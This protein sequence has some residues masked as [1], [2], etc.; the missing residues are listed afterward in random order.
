MKKVIAA[1]VVLALGGA[2]SGSAFALNWAG[3]LS[4]LGASMSDTANALMQQ[5]L[6]RQ[7]MEQQHQYQMQEL[8]AQ[9]DL[10]MRQLQEQQRLFD[11]QRLAADR[12]RADQERQKQRVAAAAAA[13]AAKSKAID[14]AQLAHLLKA[15]PNWREIVGAVDITKQ[16]PDP[17]NA[18]RKWLATKDPA[19]QAKING[20]NSPREVEKA[21]AQFQAEG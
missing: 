15:Y 21:I 7:Q 8:Q 17:D 11:E 3:G 5:E 10:Q 14:A 16:Q 4:G 18:F 20:T 9:Q 12:Q 13:A 19:Y 1:A 2:L 6:L